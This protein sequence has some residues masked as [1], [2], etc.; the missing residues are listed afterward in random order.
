M[1]FEMVLRALENIEWGGW[2]GMFEDCHL[3]WSAPRRFH[4]GR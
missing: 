1:T 3:K 2:G 4:W